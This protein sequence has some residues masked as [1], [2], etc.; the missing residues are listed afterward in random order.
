MEF[1]Q[2][3]KIRR[4]VRKF[5][6]TSVPRELLDDMIAHA[7]LAPNAGNRQPWTFIVIQD[8]A[9]M[10]QLSDD[11][12]A[13]ILADIKADPGSSLKVY[14]SHMKNP[15]FNVFYNAPCLIYIAG[16]ADIPTMAKD[17][18]LAASYLMLSAASRG[19]G[20]CWIELGR[21]I[22]DPDL[23]RTIRLPEGAE[24]HAPLV[25]GYPATIPAIP[26]RNQPVIV[27]I[28]REKGEH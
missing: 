13:S 23:I 7:T 14:E 16:R 5:K 28:P 1:S 25:V 18:A 11:S 27:N 21:F 26:K 2:L 12:K 24:I 8:P 6:D 19:L 22:R 17:C 15:D 20:S 3:L 4:S 9:L 10:K